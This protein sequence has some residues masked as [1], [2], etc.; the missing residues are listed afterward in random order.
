MNSSRARVL[1]SDIANELAN[2]GL[3]DSF[4]ANMEH[5]PKVDKDMSPFEWWETYLAW[6]ELNSEEDMERYYDTE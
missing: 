6:S 1:L 5:L 3:L 2:P 4:I